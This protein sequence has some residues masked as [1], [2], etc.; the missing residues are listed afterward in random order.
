MRVLEEI[1]KLG[2]VTM[3][4][5]LEAQDRPPR[6]GSPGDRFYKVAADFVG[7]LQHKAPIVAHLPKA[8]QRR[9]E[10]RVHE[11]LTRTR[12]ELEEYQRLLEADLR[13]TKRKSGR[14]PA[15]NLGPAD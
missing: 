7:F 10:E 8:Y 2:G 15:P 13:T 1:A 4:S 11:L 6:V 5:L 9:Y 12:R 14:S 3:S